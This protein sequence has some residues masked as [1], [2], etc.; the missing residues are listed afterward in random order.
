MKGEPIPELDCCHKTKP[1][2]STGSSLSPSLDFQSC[3][4]YQV[5]WN[6]SPMLHY[7]PAAYEGREC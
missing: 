6:P 7:K 3:Q 4:E 2:R 1:W 5:K